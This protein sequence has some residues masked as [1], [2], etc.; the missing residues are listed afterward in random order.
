MIKRSIIIGLVVLGAAGFIFW[1]W[2][3]IK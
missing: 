1:K 2:I 3:G